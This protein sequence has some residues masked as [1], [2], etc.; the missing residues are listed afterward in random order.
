MSRSFLATLALAFAVGL[1][2]GLWY[3]WHEPPPAAVPPPPVVVQT[4]PVGNGQ[5]IPPQPV[6][7]S[8][9]PPAP[10]VNPQADPAL[11]A[12][13]FAERFGTYTTDLPYENYQSV[14]GLTTSSY[15]ANLEAAAASALPVP[16][17]VY[18][19]VT[20]RALATEV[21]EQAAEVATVRVRVQR[22]DRLARDGA[23]V[24]TYPELEV[25][26]Q[27]ADGSWYV[28]AATWGQASGS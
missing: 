22:E 21:V 4:Q 28:S 1:G 6:A 2:W 26:L 16:V 24:T 15:Q 19:S 25:R 10:P 23:S 12:L 14:R 17:E 5:P 3:L 20:V 18:R 8:P 11:V 7:P 13:T 27:E 9:E